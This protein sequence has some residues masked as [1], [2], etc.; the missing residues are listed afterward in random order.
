MEVGPP[1]KLSE[2]RR[3]RTTSGQRAHR[4]WRGMA[5]RRASIVR[6]ERCR[7]VFEASFPK[8]MRFVSTNRPGCSAVAAHV[9]W[10]PQGPMRGR[11]GGPEHETPSAVGTDYC[12]VREHDFEAGA[13]AV[14]SVKSGAS[15]GDRRPGT[16]FGRRRPQ[17]RD[18][19]A[20]FRRASVGRSRSRLSRAGP[21]TGGSGRL[22]LTN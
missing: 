2:H 17:P 3:N 8:H 22:P 11:V 12:A 15:R 10:E 20:I 19:S 21:S 4:P 18:N 1:G 16:A 5:E 9:L 14:G 7:L 13:P 6:Y